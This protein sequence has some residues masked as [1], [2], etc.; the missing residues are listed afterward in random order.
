MLSGVGEKGKQV[1]MPNVFFFHPVSR[2][3]G[4]YT[5][6]PASVREYRHRTKGHEFGLVS[7]YRF[8]RPLDRSEE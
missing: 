3:V 8:F 1:E 7:L 2:A 6:A 5:R 4:D